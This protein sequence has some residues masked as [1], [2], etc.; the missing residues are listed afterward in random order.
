[1]HAVGKYVWLVYRWE[2][3]HSVSAISVLVAPCKENVRNVCVRFMFRGTCLWVFFFVNIYICA[4]RSHINGSKNFFIIIIFWCTISIKVKQAAEAQRT[5]RDIYGNSAITEC[6]YKKWF[7]IFFS[8]DTNINDAPSL[9][10]QS[11]LIREISKKL[12][13]WIHPNMGKRFLQQ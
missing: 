10:R 5:V 12:L 7:A 13:M 9:G 8:G 2:M 3:I 6:V 4:R 11:T 1:M